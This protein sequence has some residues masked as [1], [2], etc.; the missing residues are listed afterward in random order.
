[1]ALRPLNCSL[2]QNLH[3]TKTVRCT[4]QSFKNRHYPAVSPCGF[5]LVRRDIMGYRPSMKTQW[6]LLRPDAPSVET[7]CSALKC[8]PATASILVNRNICTPEDAIRF[9]DASLAHLRPPFD[10]KDMDIAVGRIVKA[11]ID[12]EKILI[13]GDYDADGVTGTAVLLDFFNRTDADATYYIPHRTK[14]GY[15]LQTRHI[16]QVASPDNVKLIITVDCGSSSHDAVALAQEEGIDVIV[17]DH[18]NVGRD[19]PP[20]I[21]VVNPKRQ[22]CPA[23]LEALSGVG[24]AFFLIIAL[25]KQLRDNGF[26]RNR[27]EPNLAQFCD[28][29]ALGTVADRVPLLWENRILS[30]AGLEKINT[31]HRPGIR[32]LVEASG[33][34]DHPVDAG[35]IAFRLAPRI[36]AAGRMAHAGVAV[37]LLMATDPSEATEAARGL[38]RLNVQRQEI[39]R[40]MLDR[41]LA[42]IKTDPGLLKKH[43]LIVDHE[44]WHEGILGIVASRLCR[45]FYRPVILISTK[46]G[47]GRGSARSIPG[48][49]LYKGLTACEGELVQFGGHPMAAGLSI[50]PAQIDRFKRKFEQVMEAMT[51]PDDFSQKTAVDYHLDLDDISDELIDELESLS[52][53]GEENPEPVFMTRHIDIVSA[54]IVGKHHRRMSIKAAS[55]RGNKRFD[56]IH[57]N[58]DPDEPL[59]AHYDHVLFRLNWNYWN[60]K[61]T[62]QVIIEAL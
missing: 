31:T 45:R 27:P 59:R 41:V 39:E 3:A 40:G 28:L 18:H 46:D 11:I 7:L 51:T 17:T 57:F 43:S 33:I 54:K 60:G 25:R 56:A 37:D 5:D 26:W 16:G 32:A 6:H 52:P 35:D 38:D 14:E 1:M 58:I 23:G 50:K 36:N 15:G 42:D 61:R 4:S 34:R 24:V 55:P 62:A 13:F 44:H 29:V 53:F 49:D 47:R 30:K 21:A 20:A 22:D 10:M 2:F 9:R 48:V 19:L 12:H 8:H